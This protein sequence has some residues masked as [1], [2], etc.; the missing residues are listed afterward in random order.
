MLPEFYDSDGVPLYDSDYA[1]MPEASKLQLARLTKQL[2][3][4]VSKLSEVQ[5]N[6]SQLAIRHEFIVS[7]MERDQATM[8][9]VIGELKDKLEVH[10]DRISKLEKMFFKFSGALVVV[11]FVGQYLV[12][13][14]FF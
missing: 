7:N 4:I 12:N 14:F 3:I 9:S 2:D 6:L 11:I 8:K 1:T 13:K 5:I 10:D